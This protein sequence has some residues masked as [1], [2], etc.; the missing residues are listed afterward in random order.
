MVCR[1]LPDQVPSEDLAVSVHLSE[2]K[3]ASV[4]KAPLKNHGG[5]RIQLV[6]RA[7]LD[8]WNVENV[9]VAGVTEVG[10]SLS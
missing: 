5:S 10:L 4:E 7:I 9:G 3:V 6:A 8:Y 1:P 2:N